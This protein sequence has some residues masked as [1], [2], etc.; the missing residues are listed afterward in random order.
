MLL[1][2]CDNE[3]HFLE[4]LFRAVFLISEI[5][6]MVVWMEKTKLQNLVWNDLGS[7]LQ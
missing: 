7:V 4:L 2:G 5:N 1:G 3:Q 6:V